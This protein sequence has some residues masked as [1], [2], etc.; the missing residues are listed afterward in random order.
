ML[1]EAF[2]VK[3]FG[4]GQ[5]KFSVSSLTDPHIKKIIDNIVATHKVSRQKI[6][7]EINEKISK[8][9]DMAK[10]SPILYETI[11]QN[12]VESEVFNLFEKY[13][14]II[15]TGPKF[16]PAIFSA[17]MKRI[18]S[19]HDQFFP[20]RNFSDNKPLYKP[21]SILVPNDKPENKQYN[22]VDT[23]AAT[24]TGEFIFSVPFMQ[25]LLDFAHVK[26]IQPK[27]KKYKCNGG[28]IP[29][30]YAYIEFLII[31]EFMH[32]SH[33]DFHF[34]KIIKD[35][36]PEIIN[37]VGD[38]RTNYLLVKS[39]F[40]QLPMGLF[41][42]HV[43][44]DRQES[45][46]EMYDLVKKEFDKLNKNQQQQ[47]KNQLGGM[48]KGGHGKKNKNSSG[49]EG[50]PSEGDPSEKGGEDKAG[51]GNGGEEGD[52]KK[53]AGEGKGGKPGE[54]SKG[55]GDDGDDSSD[56]KKPGE[57][58][59][60][61]KGGDGS[62]DPSKVDPK[63]I[64][65]ENKRIE[66]AMARRE[67]KGSKEEMPAQKTNTSNT[68][69]GGGGRGNGKD[70]GSSEFD[71]SKV[72]PRFTWKE[73]L[74]KMISDGSSKTEETYQRIH[75]RNITGVD[76]ARQTGSAAM[77]PG[78]I[79]L[80]SELKLCFVVDTS[81]SMSGVVPTIY[82]NIEELLKKF[83]STVKG[84]EF[85]LIKFSSS[86]YIYKCN[87]IKDSYKE[88]ARVDDNTKTIKSGSVKKLF[89]QHIGDATNFTNTM[90]KDINHLLK[91]K[92]N[93]VI[94]SDSDVLY[95]ENF[96]NV[97]SILTKNKNAFLILDSQNTFA[98]F[99]KAMGQVPG[100]ITYFK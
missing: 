24:P 70:K 52:D 41:S 54:P 83:K 96:E 89:S 58:T 66:D 53:P 82:A 62:F 90:T 8:F 9:A 73:L 76:L 65:D 19:E 28:D 92:F 84:S 40:E 51:S 11:M 17:L 37:W 31:H 3:R 35:S 1:N 48:P 72:K 99:A 50:D 16:K 64:D 87:Y 29:D 67:E 86:H 6:E 100:N 32:F 74:R 14:D 98:Q 85:F 61:G 10:T 36:D 2:N 80:E 26:G 46:M 7:D 43:N 63:I 69:T 22:D 88:L 30:E 45:Y 77:K 39:G 56:D 75:R 13:K 23:A 93:T 33:A 44:L 25:K 42:D 34:Q 60:T 21:I 20:L 47:V 49:G 91:N 38:F 4:P 71:Y 95:G 59:G 15:T 78:D 68:K 5:L 79:E 18:R 81:G 57:G 55:A 12:I 97:K 27:G 94:L